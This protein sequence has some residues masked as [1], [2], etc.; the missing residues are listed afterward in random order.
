ML[1]RE[2]ATAVGYAVVE[3][4]TELSRT[5]VTQR[6]MCSAGAAPATQPQSSAGSDE[7]QSHCAGIGS[8]RGRCDDRGI[9]AL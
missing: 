7:G 1:H 5:I 4:Q 8:R 9:G 3:F 2:M 6:L